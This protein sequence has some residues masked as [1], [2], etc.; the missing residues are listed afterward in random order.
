MTGYIVA[1]VVA[2]IT[3]IG[4]SGL[5]QHFL[6][7]AQREA[8]NQLKAQE[9]D[10]SREIAETNKR[11]ILAQAQIAAQQAA[12][13]SSDERYNNLK[14]DYDETRKSLK[15][16]RYATETLID[17]VD[18]LVSKMRPDNGEQ[19]ISVT[20]TAAEYLAARSAIREARAHLN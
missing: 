13:D 2:V 20:V 19:I 15:D 16:L 6:T 9:A 14:G 10:Q 5:L 4:G 3:A 1:I 12:L 7:K 18:T 8:D 11:D 17:V